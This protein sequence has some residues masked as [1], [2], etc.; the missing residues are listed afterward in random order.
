MREHVN[1]DRIGVRHL[2]RISQEVITLRQRI[3]KELSLINCSLNYSWLDANSLQQLKD[4]IFYE[5]DLEKENYQV[6]KTK[7]LLNKYLSFSLN[8]N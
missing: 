7:I 8:R 1:Y 3:D 6:R 5:I 2:Y 4:Q